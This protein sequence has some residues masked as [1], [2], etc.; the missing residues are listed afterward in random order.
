MTEQLNILMVASEN[1]GLKDAKVGGIG[2]VVRDV[3]LALANLTEQDCRVTIV[4]PSYGFVHKLP[5]SKMLSTFDFTFAGARDKIDLYEVP[6][7]KPHAKVRHLV[8]HHPHFEFLDPVTK[9]LRIYCDDPPERPFATDATKFARFCAAVAEGLKQ[10]VL[11]SVNRLH[12]HDWHAAFLLILSRFDNSFEEINQIRTVYTI[13]NL[14]LQGIR[15]FR[16]DESSLEAW[17]PHLKYTESDLADPD[18]KDCLNPMAAGIRFA[19]AVHVVSP[20]YAEEIIKPSIPQRND[21]NCV[22]YG[23]EGLEKDLQATKEKQR[24]FGILNGCDYAE[25]RKMPPR[26]LNAYKNLLD[27]LHRAIYAWGETGLS[28]F[29]LL[30]LER[31]RQL[32]QAA[33]KRPAVLLTS[34]TRVVD[35]KVLLMRRQEEKKDGEPQVKPALERIL[36]GLDEEK[37][38][39]LLG[40]GDTTHEQFLFDLSYRFSNFVFMKGYDNGCAADLYENGDLFLMPSSFEPCGISQMLAMRSGQPCVVHEVGGLID[41]ITNDVDGFSFAGEDP[42]AQA[43]NFVQAVFKAINMVCNAPD[44]FQEIRNAA[45]QKQFLWSSS[46]RE[47]IEKLY[48]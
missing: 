45:F 35:Q 12:L 9:K 21:P 8:L 10:K 40:T 34:V 33:A 2:D 16:G 24:L 39:I 41:T 26:D 29:H 36:E 15:P 20:T 38:Y 47:Y 27:R 42:K 19:D 32:R 18:Y 14:V 44:R 4:V 30:A 7:Q 46:V 43:E 22:F 48:T 3:P 31:I 6:G 11:G 5:G 25:D 13:H 28:S 23:G 37:V 17:F 1:D